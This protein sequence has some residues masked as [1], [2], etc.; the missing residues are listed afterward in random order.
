M[1][2]SWEPFDPGRFVSWGNWPAEH[3][4]SRP[5]AEGLD[6]GNA[7]AGI[8]DGIVVVQTTYSPFATSTARLRALKTASS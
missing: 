5:A 2:A 8:D 4:G 7:P 1:F 3:R 6:K